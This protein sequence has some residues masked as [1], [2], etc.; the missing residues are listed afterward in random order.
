MVTAHF[1]FS[2]IMS[3]GEEDAWKAAEEGRAE[4]NLKCKYLSGLK[5][6]LGNIW[7]GLGVL[8]NHPRKG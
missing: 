3:E 2:Q 8:F 7:P 1:S 5:A 4:R 6:A